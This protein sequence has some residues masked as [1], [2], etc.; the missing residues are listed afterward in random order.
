MKNV[1]YPKLT[2]RFLLVLFL[3]VV[4]NSAGIEASSAD[5]IAIAWKVDKP[6]NVDGD[7]SEW[8]REDPLF[9]GR[10]DQVNKHAEYWDGPDDNSGNFYLM[11]DSDN[12][13]LAAEIVDDVPFVRFMAYGLDSIDGIAIYLSTNP[14]AERGRA[15]YDSTDFRLLFGLDND[16]LDTGIDRS[17]VLIKKG[18]DTAGVDGYEN[19]IKGCEVAIKE[20]ELGFNLEIKIPF[21]SLSNDQIP[22]LKPEPGMEV[23]FNLELYDLDQACPG[24]VATGLVWKAGNPKL[25]PKDWGLLRFQARSN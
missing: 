3:F 13:Y 14:E 6:V 11:W 15:I 23:G 1:S 5:D 7:L 20:S 18:I 4:I 16:M 8:D 10:E 21:S 19:A 25:S 24:S 17:N 22:V 2:L 9:L 12:L